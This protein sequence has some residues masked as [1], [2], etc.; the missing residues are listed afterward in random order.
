MVLG[1]FAVAFAAKKVAPPVSLGTLFLAASMLDMICSVLVLVGVERFE[2]APGN[3]AATPL[4]FVHYP[5]SHSL[6]MAVVWAVLFGAAYWGWRRD[7]NGALWV[8]LAIFSHWVLD[9]IAHRPDLPLY[10][11]GASMV[12]LGL[13]NSIAGTVTVEGLMFAGALALYVNSTRA[14][15]GIGKYALWLLVAILLL[16]YTATIFG[17]PAPSARAVS[18]VGLLGGGLSVAW[19]YWVDRHRT[20][21]N[22]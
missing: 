8:A 11:G 12:G 10:P 21:P 20:I 13:W 1:H 18:S 6:L 19:A 22:P 4:A 9:A 16:S 17:P 14:T 2:I 15:D 3:T 5:Y 7:A